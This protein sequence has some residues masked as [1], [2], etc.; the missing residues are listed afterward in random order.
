M[1]HYNDKHF[2]F[3]NTKV[4]LSAQKLR[5]SCTYV[6][7]F[8]NPPFPNRV[9]LTLN[10]TFFI[11][12]NRLSTSQQACWP[13]LFINFNWLKAQDRNKKAV[14]V[15]LDRTQSKFNTDTHVIQYIRAY[16]LGYRGMVLQVWIQNGFSIAI[17][18]LTTVFHFNFCSKLPVLQVNDVQCKP[19]G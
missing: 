7:K 15:I 9:D 4:F 1:T 11:L 16:E 5:N 10:A 19:R 12:M 13:K 3:V 2:W 18:N 14:I 6:P 8:S 17:L